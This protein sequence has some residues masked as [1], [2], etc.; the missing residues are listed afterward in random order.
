MQAHVTAIDEDQDWFRIQLT[1]TSTNPVEFPLIG[2]VV[3]ILHDSFSSPEQAIAVQ[4]GIANLELVAWGAFT[5]SVCVN[6]KTELELD[7]ASPEVNAP[8]M[9]KKR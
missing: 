6:G 3:F 9:F 2:T 4:N 5:V 1:V 8:E 7:L